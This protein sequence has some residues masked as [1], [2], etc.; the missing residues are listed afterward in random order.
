MKD[1]SERKVIG[2]FVGLKSDVF[3]SPQTQNEK[4]SK[5]KT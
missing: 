3:K 2:E 4:N 5:Q 1:E